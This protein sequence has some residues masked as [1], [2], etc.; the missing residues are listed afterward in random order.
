M[1]EA[2][3]VTLS[4]LGSLEASALESAVKPAGP[5]TTVAGSALWAVVEAPAT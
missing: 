4:L 1:V 5:A 2:A 3:A